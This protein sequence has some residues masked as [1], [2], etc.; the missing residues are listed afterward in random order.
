[1]QA[2]KSDPLPEN[3]VCTPFSP[4]STRGLLVNL[5]PREE[6]L[7]LRLSLFARQNRGIAFC[8]SDEP[9]IHT[10][11]DLYL[12]PL[13]CLFW[14]R[15]VT[16]LSGKIIFIY[17]P[18]YGLPGSFLA[19]CSDY[20]REP[21]DERELL[22]RAQRIRNAVN[23]DYPWGSLRLRNN[24]CIG[25]GGSAVLS[26]AEETILRTLV[27]NRQKRVEKEL[28]SHLVWGIHRKESRAIDMH[29]AKLR[30]KMKAALPPDV[31]TVILTCRP[32]GYMLR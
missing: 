7:E 25:P 29:I 8:F 4:V 24:E 1:V 15:S 28:L 13:S 5:A 23:L 17:G 16:S 2:D 18:A 31:R 20:L 10:R 30:K 3:L 22:A 14:L 27:R 6:K 32:G 26:P 19:G 9:L 11:I 21:W 12:I